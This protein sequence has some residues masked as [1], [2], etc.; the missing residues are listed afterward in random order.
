MSNLWRNRFRLASAIE[1]NEEVDVARHDFS[2]HVFGFTCR[3]G[4]CD[5]SSI[6]SR[7][8]QPAPITKKRKQLFREEHQ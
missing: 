6:A 7:S 8:V 1:K 3:I 4:I 5:A 2:Y